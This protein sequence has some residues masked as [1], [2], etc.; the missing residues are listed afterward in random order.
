MLGGL[1]A[2]A[3]CLGCL[4]NWPGCAKEDVE[5]NT[6]VVNDSLLVD[7]C[8]LFLGLALVAIPQMARK[9]GLL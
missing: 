2:M 5:P 3:V 4:W 9:M 1:L 6:V 8:F 7:V